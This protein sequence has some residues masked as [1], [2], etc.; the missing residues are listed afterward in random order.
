MALRPPCFYARC[1]VEFAA[2]IASRR[3]RTPPPPARPLHAQTQTRPADQI[4]TPFEC[5]SYRT[6]VCLSMCWARV[7]LSIVLDSPRLTIDPSFT[8]WPG[9]NW[10]RLSRDVAGRAPITS[11]TSP[12]PGATRDPVGDQK[13]LETPLQTPAITR[14]Q[15]IP[16]DQMQPAVHTNRVQLY[17]VSEAL[18]A[19]CSQ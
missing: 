7:C 5:L 15:L 14:Y 2:L 10:P 17:L 9:T 16:H 18:T 4:I 13:D 12:P 3:I 6:R 11:S 19:R 1:C 8:E